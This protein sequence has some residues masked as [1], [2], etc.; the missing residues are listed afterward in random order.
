MTGAASRRQAINLW[1]KR[2][3]ATTAATSAAGAAKTGVLMLNMGGPR[4]ADDVEMFLRR[5]FEDRDIIKLPFQG[6]ALLNRIIY[7]SLLNKMPE[8]LSMKM[9]S[10]EQCKFL[11]MWLRESHRL[12]PCLHREFHAT[13]L[14]KNM[15]F[16]ERQD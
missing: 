4:T 13:S 5:L 15:S 1:Q 16:L 3:L 12:L 14:R 2:Q 6:F 8:R 7:G 9:V 11:S 10:S